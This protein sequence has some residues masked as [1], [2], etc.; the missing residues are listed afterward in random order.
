M[1]ALSLPEPMAASAS[2]EMAAV[3]ASAERDHSQAADASASKVRRPT[4]IVDSDRERMVLAVHVLLVGSEDTPDPPLNRLDVL[5]YVNEVLLKTTM[6]CP[7]NWFGRL[8]AQALAEECDLDG[9]TIDHSRDL[10]QN[11]GKTL[12]A[13]R[14]SRPSDFLLRKQTRQRQQIEPACAAAYRALVPHAP[15]LCAS[16]LDPEHDHH[17]CDALHLPNLVSSEPLDLSPSPGLQSRA[18]RLVLERCVER[19]RRTNGNVDAKAKVR[20]AELVDLMENYLA[21]SDLLPAIRSKRCTGGFFSRH[22]MG[23]AISNSPFWGDVG[24]NAKSR[25]FPGYKI[26]PNKPD[27]DTMRRQLAA[28]FGSAPASAPAPAVSA[29]ER[30]HAETLPPVPEASDSAVQLSAEQYALLLGS[31]RAHLRQQ[32]AAAVQRTAQLDAQIASLMAQRTAVATS[33]ERSAAMLSRF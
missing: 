31:A 4:S 7:V 2:A 32:Q 27:V 15:R 19:A 11:G 6:S 1:P 28:E 23:R 5:H 8:F 22:G 17:E 12:G 29:A 33:A 30:K 24:R 20:S 25:S 14:L 16:A 13:V 9:C 18:V 26:N 10:L 21:S 3:G